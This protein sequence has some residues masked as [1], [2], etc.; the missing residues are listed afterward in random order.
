MNK[1]ELRAV[2]KYL[3][4]KINTS[5]EIKAGMTDVYGDPDPSLSTLKYGTVEFKG[6]RTSVFTDDRPLY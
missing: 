3:F 6:Q 2:T 4:L 5:D 1:I